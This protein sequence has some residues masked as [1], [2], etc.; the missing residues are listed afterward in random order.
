[1]EQ[2]FKWLLTACGGVIT[3]LFGA[4][5]TMLDILIALMIIEYVSG[6]AAA[7]IHG[8]LKSR[9]GFMGIA[10]KVFVLVMIAVS[11]L[12]DLLLNEN[13]IEMGFLIMSLVISAYCVNE[14]LSI[15]ENAGKIGVYV[16]DP[17]MK[18][19]AILKNKPEK[20]ELKKE[21]TEKVK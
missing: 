4:W 16:P 19:I 5:S 3:F 18:A 9:V 8:E 21:S 15:T 12:V 14:L 6:M 17:L 11:H 10:R 1:M 20:E 13:N 7:A 2:F